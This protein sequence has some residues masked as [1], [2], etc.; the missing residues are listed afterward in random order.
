MST[1]THI[2]IACSYLHVPGG[3]E[4]AMITTA[5]LFAE[6]GHRVTLLVLDQTAET[7]YP[8][9]PAVHI[10]HQ[11]VNFGITEKGNF[12]S[13]KLWLWRDIRKMKRLVK[14]LQPDYLICSEYPFAAGAILAGAKKYCRVYSWEHHHYGAQQLNTFWKALVRRTYKQLDTV[15]CQNKDEQQ[16]YRAINE[17][18]T[19]NPNN[20]SPP[21]VSETNPEK[22]FEL[23]SVTRF[24]LIKGVDLLM[25][26]AKIILPANPELKWKVTGYGEQKDIFLDFIQKENL[27]GQLIYQPADKPDITEDYRRAAVLVMTSRNECFPLALLEAMSN[28]LPCI[29][30]DCDTGPRHII[31]HQETGLLVE[32]E[33]IQEMVAAI[34]TLVNNKAM[35]KQMGDNALKAVQSFYRGKVYAMWA[36]LFSKN[37]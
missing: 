7:Y 15:I 14:Q 20:I 29:A 1:K 5:G 26:V 13:R 31:R 16:Y 24:N 33:N 10:V 18:A 8:V 19:V 12:I 17:R 23:I 11:P 37:K 30:F 3:Y 28:G 9:H 34:T 25:Q 27:S 2:V 4:K 35:Q 32:K 22:D 6:K 36:E 21:Q